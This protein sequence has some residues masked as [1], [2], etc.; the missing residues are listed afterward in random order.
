MHSLR[1]A[2][3]N[4]PVVVA[5]QVWRET[6]RRKPLFLAFAVPHTYHC[7]FYLPQGRERRLVLIGMASG[8][9]SS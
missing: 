9:S 5:G 6:R 3:R 8:V 2:N 7:H 4:T 1:Q